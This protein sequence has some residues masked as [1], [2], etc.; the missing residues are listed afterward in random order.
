[1]LV[2]TPSYFAKNNYKSP[3]DAYSG[4]FQYAVG[5]KRHYFD[6]LAEDGAQQAAFNSLMRVSRTNRGEDWFD[7]FPVE[8]KLRVKDAGVPLLVDIG[9]GVGHDITAFKARY[10]SLPGRLILQ[11]LPATI[12][13]VDVDHVGPGVEIMEYNF[14]DLQPVKDA[15]AYYLRTVLVCQIS[16]CFPDQVDSHVK[17]LEERNNVL[18]IPYFR[19]NTASFRYV[20]KISQTNR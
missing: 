1:M 13:D 12:A 11:D 9:G 7:F 5:T 16:Q 14:F 3:A 18:N 15:R 8:E 20:L 2:K 4:P 17:A 10:P 6:W 19:N